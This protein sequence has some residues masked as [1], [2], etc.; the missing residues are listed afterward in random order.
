MICNWKIPYDE[1]CRKLDL[2]KVWGVQ[3][4]ILVL[5]FVS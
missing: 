1:C 4:V 5:S 2:C 3:I